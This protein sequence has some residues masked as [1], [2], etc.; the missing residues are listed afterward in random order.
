MQFTV[1]SVQCYVYSVQCSGS[2]A[3]AGDTAAVPEVSVC[4]YRISTTLQYSVQYTAVQYL[5][6]QN[7][8]LL[9]SA[10]QCLVV[11][12]LQHSTVKY[13]TDTV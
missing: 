1:I 7:T 5:A 6:V 10:G 4:L 2:F 13:S 9:Y 3:E 11:Q 8:A 12:K